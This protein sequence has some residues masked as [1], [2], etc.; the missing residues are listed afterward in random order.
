ML[1]LPFFVS[2]GTQV[3][4]LLLSCCCLVVGRAAAA[5]VLLLPFLVHRM[6]RFRKIIQ[7]LRD[8]IKFI[9]LHML[10]GTSYKSQ[11]AGEELPL[12]D[13][14][15]IV[16]DVEGDVESNFTSRNA[17]FTSVYCDASGRASCFS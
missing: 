12:Q 11:S 13:G 1:L 14:E 2:D 10:P 16:D 7:F 8:I 5:V 4:L 6:D 9:Q 15:P 3:V 17:S